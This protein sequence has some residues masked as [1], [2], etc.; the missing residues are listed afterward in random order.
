MPAKKTRSRKS[1][2]SAVP[3][4]NSVLLRLAVGA[5][6]LGMTWAAVPL[7][8]ALTTSITAVV[9][10]AFSAAVTSPSSGTSVTGSV[11]FEARVPAPASSGIFQVSG[12]PNGTSM[13]VQG[14]QDAS[15]PLKWTAK[16]D[17]TLLSAGTYSLAFSAVRAVDGLTATSPQISLVVPDQTPTYTITF[18][19]P[20]T[21]S[22]VTDAVALTA[23][24]NRAV[25]SL[26][27]VVTP[28]NGG[29]LLELKT[30]FDSKNGTWVGSW[31][32]AEYPNGTYTIVAHAFHAAVMELSDPLTI[33]VAN[34]APPPVF[35]VSLR[36][37][38]S[39]G[40]VKGVTTL[41]S[42]TNLAATGLTYV[43]SDATGAPVASLNAA[44]S[45][46]SMQWDAQWDTTAVPNGTYSVVA[47][48]IRTGAE[49]GTSPASFTVANPAD[50]TV[51]TVLVA[52]PSKDAVVSG[53]VQVYAQT[54][55]AADTV[56][57][58]VTQTFGSKRSVQLTASGGPTSWYAPWDASSW[59]P[60]TYL[61][62]ATALKGSG[63]NVS[64]DVSF[65][66]TA[67]SSTSPVQV[68]TSVNVT[69]PIAGA[70]VSG[71]V[72]LSA[73]TDAA[74]DLAGFELRSAM[75]ADAA[76]VA[77][78]AA[79]GSDGGQSWTAT[80]NTTS[81]PDGD[82]VVVAVVT[83]NG[84]RAASASVPVHLKNLTS[85]QVAVPS[86]EIRSP[87]QGATVSGIV[88]LYAAS[89]SAIDGL[90]FILEGP[91][92]PGN[93]LA[94]PAAG[95][96]EKTAWTVTWNTA[97]ITD[98]LVSLS[99]VASKS[100]HESQGTPRTFTVAN[101]AKP[102]ETVP[103]PVQPPP[104]PPAGT[105]PSVAKFLVRI[106]APP[107]GNVVSGQVPLA[108]VVEGGTALTVRFAIGAATGG[109][110]AGIDARYDSAAKRWVATWKSDGSPAGTY[111]VSASAQNA[112]GETVQSEPTKVMIGG[113]GPG[114][115]VPP[116]GQPPLA[117]PNSEKQVLSAKMVF[118]EP[119]AVLRGGTTLLAEAPAA[120][121]V[122]FTVRA[123]GGREVQRP[124][125]ADGIRWSAY[126][127][128][129]ALPDGKYGIEAYATDAGGGHAS[130]AR[131]MV[132]IGNGGTAPPVSRVDVVP[133]PAVVAA[134][135]E[136]PPGSVSLSADPLPQAVTDAADRLNAECVAKNVPLERCAEWL[137]K[138]ASQKE[139]AAA[140]IVTKEECLAYLKSV[141]GGQ[142]PAC[143]GKSDDECARQVAFVTADLMPNADLQAFRDAAMQNVGK[144]VRMPPRGKQGDGQQGVPPAPQAM[145]DR[146]P[147][148]G[149]SA[150][151]VEVH[152][153]PGFGIVDGNVAFQTLPAFVMVDVDNDGLP[154]DIE[155]R[156]GTDPR[157]PDTD[158]DGYGDGLEVERGYSPLGPGVL[159]DSIALAP[160][161][162]A[163]I[164]GI[165]IEQPKNAGVAVDDLKVDT[166]VAQP[167]K[168]GTF[169]IGG[170]AKPRDVVTVFVY[171]DLPVVF[172]TAAKDDGTWTYDLGSGLADGEHEAYATVTDG[173]GK[174]SAKSEPL[175]FFVSGAKAVTQEDF[176]NPTT[177]PLAAAAAAE[178]SRMLLGW[179]IG[180]VAM[181]MGIALIASFLL[182]MRPK[183][184]APPSPPAPPAP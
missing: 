41:S 48:S 142:L 87:A 79:S 19:S 141:H 51:L 123:D 168:A 132:I 136:R 80:L 134:V 74:V 182:F 111:V 56:S 22:T 100:G 55:L 39:G 18:V 50:S 162:Q 96:A 15:D 88:P 94:L 177:S 167:E 173:T 67:P 42:V 63:T 101:A 181:V 129:T 89:A 13:P 20:K 45:N 139:C 93:R 170:R 102:A 30:N 159:T 82:Y 83:R 119:A 183:K 47:K 148:A 40:S 145:A 122:T 104:V 28:P 99:A 34:A 25:D 37:P 154:D 108:A 135:L 81:I 75:A 72:S 8:K 161:D 117:P 1:P 57:F 143:L 26:T 70:T 174:I 110:T 113:S 49:A 59:E 92:V 152:A 164:S 180:A 46:G 178:P 16:F 151:N 184:G 5:V 149:D 133:A 32:T 106:V 65:S 171:S 33:T 147:F 68:T 69:V 140:G 153:S 4:G 62:R 163:V 126:L 29:G 17:T 43:V 12:G 86:F 169:T 156:I 124:A 7:A 127:D 90:A 54:S 131:I 121:A 31:N 71:Q 10:Q 115:P 107:P 116:S 35:S 165:A 105:V 157:N 176:F 36:A 150:V 103:P 130:S 64:S 76:P 52:A 11:T 66:V 128:T 38:A 166:A 114:T 109:A 112:K 44:P 78:V 61:I 60:G 155:L 6:L 21:G 91:T 118:P 53:P 95:N 2:K 73:R 144:V 58:N 14:T 175:A 77:T 158:G 172:T 97:M 3:F 146:S 160:V 138:Q 179:Y 137:A 84:V 125:A 24:V 85:G 9:D 120:T 27:F 98:G 23:G